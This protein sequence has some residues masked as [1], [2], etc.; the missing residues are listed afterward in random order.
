MKTK[1][2]MKNTALTL[3]ALSLSFGA[4]LFLQYVLE[5]H[6]L[7]SAVFVLG[8]YAVAYFTD[9]YIYGLSAAT[10]GMLAVNF[11]FTF[12]FFEFNF[13]IPENA[14]SAVIFLSVTLP[15][16]ALTAKIKKWEALR[17]EGEREKMRANL[18]R[19]ISHDLRTP[20]TTI[21]GSATAMLVGYD[22]LSDSQKK[23]MLNAITDDTDWL[24]RMVENLLSVTRLDDGALKLKL[25][26]TAVEE[27][28]DSAIRKLY[29][30]YPDIKVELDIPDEF[31]SVRADAMLIEQVLLNLL[32]N[33]VVHAKGMT[34]LSLKIY[35]KD[36]YA[37]FDVT[38]DGD[39]IDKAIVPDIFKGLIR[40][41]DT[42]HGMGIGLSVCASIIKAHEGEI[43]VKPG[44]TRGTT[45]SFTLPAEDYDSTEISE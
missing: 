10:V 29:K 17:V 14:V 45:F 31:I 20:L 23:E 26:S 13:T 2:I 28:A 40:A 5:A 9:G 3:T 4:S 42:K 6:E 15:T 24:M 43:C 36:G 30:R 1:K 34:R 38:D 16:C 19:A 37:V 21:Y 7:V 22:T 11:A 32:E 27:L 35:E 18:L 12:P 25:S 33:S 8:V 39:G 44:V 41:S